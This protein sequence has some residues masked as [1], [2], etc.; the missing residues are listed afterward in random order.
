MT[1]DRN[2][3]FC[4]LALQMDFV[5]RDAVI[6]AVNAWV[7][8]KKKPLGQLLVERNILREDTRQLLEALVEKHV[9]LHGGDL[10]KS[11]ASVGSVPF[12]IHEL[13]QFV[14]EPISNLAPTLMP[15]RHPPSTDETDNGLCSA[16][17]SDGETLTARPPV[18]A[19]PAAGSAPSS[20]PRF[21]VLRLH[22]QGGLGQVYLARDEELGR[23]VA[24]KEIQLQYADDPA[25][26]ARFVL[27][28]EVTGKLEHP[29]I[30]PVY[31]LGRYRD[32][33][34]YYAMRFIRGDSLQDV[35]HRFHESH[36]AVREP[37]Q[38]A[39]DLRL[40]LRRFV[41]VC[42]AIAYAHSRG[43]L[44]RDIKPA[45]VM[46][47][48]YGETLVLDWGL[49]KLVGQTDVASSSVGGA[50]VDTLRSTAA[51]ACA[52]TQVGS[53][54]GTPA[55]MSPEQAAGELNKLGQASDVY[56][57]GA[58]L[59][60]LLTGKPPIE[61]KDLGLVLERVQKGDFP[62][63]RQIRKDVPVG[64]EAICLKAMALRPEDRYGS[65]EALADEVE[66]WLADE[67]VQAHR[68]PWLVRTR[69]WMR[70]HRTAVTASAAALVVAFLCV[71]VAAAL[72]TQA[73]GHLVQA[74]AEEERAKELAL[75]RERDASEQRDHALAN[76]REAE[77]QRERSHFYLESLFNMK[78]FGRSLQS[79][80]LRDD[81]DLKIHLINGARGRSRAEVARGEFKR[82][83][84]FC[85]SVESSA[86]CFLHVFYAIPDSV[87]ATRWTR[88][89]SIVGVY[90][91]KVEKNNKIAR[92]SKRLLLNEPGLF[93]SPVV[94]S[95]D[96]AYLYV[97]ATEKDWKFRPDGD[98][99]YFYTFS[100]A[101]AA[102]LARQIARIVEGAGSSASSERQK[103]AEEIFVFY[104]R[105]KAS[106]PGKKSP[107]QPHR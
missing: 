68:E 97:L 66:H 107:P 33:R 63:P 35:I 22:A 102:D 58:T 95:G 14:D 11:L 39:M 51:T 86:D 73:N 13:Q 101:A 40:L 24:L 1:A 99:D 79:H 21:R 23:E 7:L 60:S 61:G 18:T 42:N 82:E 81:F 49:A 76:L 85:L 96:L 50:A 78:R 26:Q 30:V 38:R 27:E 6:G 83:Q 71:S 87:I 8:D 25:S 12:A 48:Q 55:Y 94:T 104:V 45:N 74:K 47:G 84:K 17:S 67:P 15:V 37:G 103:V 2:L 105:S 88:H 77:E 43:V 46:L 36:Q 52:H 62:P 57:L 106:G 72:L 90:P 4:M 64:L 75:R 34:P 44:N 80:P 20:G 54:M 70:R 65:A 59:Y 93:L 10:E 41:D 31:G 89:H 91:N 53:A 32:G 56:S 28:G 9:E 16:P 98:D 92:S 29:G 100:P 19:A 3:L 5:S 69:R